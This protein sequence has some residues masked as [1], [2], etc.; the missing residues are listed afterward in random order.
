MSLW[1]SFIDDYVAVLR[2]AGMSPNTVRAR[3]EQL[4]HIANRVVKPP[5]EVSTRDLVD[6]FGAQVWARETRR[7]R[8]AAVVGFYAW[9]VSEGL[10][11]DNPALKIP[12]I[13]PGCPNPNPVPDQV[14]LEALVRADKD[15]ALWID[16][17]A[18]H[19]LRRAEIAGL[20]SR[21]IVQTLLGHD[22]TFAGKGGKVRTVPLTRAMARALI[23]RGEGWLFPG[24][25]GGH[26]SARWL[27]KRVSRLLPGE[28]TLHKLRHRAATRFW[29]A[30]E[31][32]PYAVADLMGWANLNMVR[33]YVKQS[34]DRLRRIVEAAAG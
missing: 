3:S 4:N 16:L 11:V 10:C 32:D 7:S 29:V 27:G 12:V 34:D 13:K 17:A 2:V 33:V 20:H 15:E 1:I 14:Y 30:A 9:A 18:E 19:G 22:L 24:Y 8:R 6:Y 5:F 28:W 23:A 31:G 25:E 21:N 26:I